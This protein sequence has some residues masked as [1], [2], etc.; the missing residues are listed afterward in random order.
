MNQLDGSASQGM[1][2]VLCIVFLS[3]FEGLKALV[4][5]KKRFFDAVTILQQQ[6]IAETR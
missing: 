2:Y 1:S 4:E 3:V 6:H 5:F